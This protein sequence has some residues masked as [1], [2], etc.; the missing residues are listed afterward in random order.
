MPKLSLR[1]IVLSSKELFIFAIPIVLGQLG[2]MLIGA[3][4]VLVAAK[5]STEAVAATGVATGFISPLFVAGLS[6]LAGISPILA[7]R[8]G[9]G[10]D[11]GKYLVT[12]IVYA[13]IVAII[14]QL[15]TLLLIQFIPYFNFEAKLIPL[16]RQYSI[17]FSFSFLGAFIFQ[18]VKEFLQSF[19]DVLFSNAL[20]VIAVISN[21][22]LNYVFVFGL[23]PIPSYGV[24][25]LAIAS[26]I[27]RISLA[28]AIII[29]AKKY[30]HSFSIFT[31]LFWE[32]TKL[33]IPI[34]FTVGMEVAAFG[35]SSILT[36]MMGTI[37]A[38][39]H[40]VILTLASITFMVPLAVSNAVAVKVGHAI[41]EKRIDRVFLFIESALFL[42]LTFMS[43]SGLAFYFFPEYCLKLF[44]ADSQ[45]I[46]VGV[47]ILFIVALFQLFDGVQ[48][49]LSGVLRGLGETYRVFFIIMVSYW[50]IGLPLGSYLAFNHHLLARGI[51]IGL[52]IGLCCQAIGVSIL[53]KIT[54]KK[55]EEKLILCNPSIL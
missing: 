19:E 34:A 23:G 5:Y 14:T 48:V 55:V 31:T 21:I 44:S 11:V 43:C 42:S 12:S 49:T 4:D 6:C 32:I 51:W 35:L 3:G 20:S 29:Y 17:A 53:L 36:G 38:A 8:R 54:T 41:G 22:A 47:P 30:L 24:V 10:E 50:I 1:K 33:S 16:I 40:N 37:Q 13:V 52:A 18:A 7:K 27:T 46:V 45:L 26:I 9:E 25:G 2:Q 39:A 15:L 28:I